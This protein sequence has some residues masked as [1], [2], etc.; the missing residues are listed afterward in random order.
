MDFTTIT[1]GVLK[2]L[3]TIAGSYGLGIILLTCAIRLILWPLNVSQQR[4]MKQMQTLQPKMKMI[5]D[6]YKSDPQTMQR[7]MMEFYKE[8]KFNPMAGCL[9]LLLQMPVFILL[10]SALMSPQFIEMAGNSKFLFINRL[11]ATLRGNA[12]HSYDGSFN[13]SKSDTFIISKKVKVFLGAEELDDVKLLNSKNALKVQGDVVPGETVDF[14]ISLDEL[15]LK[16]SQLEKVT[17]AQIDVSDRTTKE[18]EAITFIRKDNILVASAPT[19]VVK[20]QFN[21]DVLVLVLIFGASMFVSQ[22]IM[23]AANKNAPMDPNQEAMQKTMGA[24][25]PIML[26]ATFVFIPIPA[27]VL[28]YL[29][30]SNIIQVIQTVVINKQLELEDLKKKNTKATDI[31]NAKPVASKEVKTIEAEV[32]S[33]ESETNS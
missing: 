15:D 9:P 28:L 24:M 11:D 23:M 32:I 31:A 1:I 14:K 16:Y 20:S 13:V 7:K 6:R 8:H 5:Q 19:A 18:V 2:S 33:A 30:A 3:S 12:G 21:F 22:K 25:M 27:G 4:S 29:V 10:Y 17:K 26:T